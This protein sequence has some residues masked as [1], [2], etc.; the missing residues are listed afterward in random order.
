MIYSHFKPLQLWVNCSCEHLLKN[1]ST[2]F[3]ILVGKLSPKREIIR[4]IK[5]EFSSAELFTMCSSGT[6]EDKADFLSALGHCVWASLS[7]LSVSGPVHWSVNRSQG[8]PGGSVP[9]AACVAGADIWLIGKRRHFQAAPKLTQGNLQH[10]QMGLRSKWWG[11]FCWQALFFLPCRYLCADCLSASGCCW[12]PGQC[13]GNVSQKPPLPPDPADAAHGPAGRHLE[14]SRIS[15]LCP[16]QSKGGAR[17][18]LGLGE[19]C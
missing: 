15:Y 1:S 17:A 4:L 14:T 3:K 7:E 8:F 19:K 18:Q 5:S 10:S 16:Q 2:D 12:E 9:D 6:D 13:S 11:R